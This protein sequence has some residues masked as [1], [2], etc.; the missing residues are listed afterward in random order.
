MSREEWREIP[1]WE[2]LYMAS[3]LGRVR[4][5]DRT[6]IKKV[7]RNGRMATIQ[8]KGKI[9]SQSL[10]SHGYPMLNLC[11]GG[12]RSAALVHQLVLFAFVGPKPEGM[13]SRHLDG[14]RSN[15]RIENLCWGTALENAADKKRHGTEVVIC[16]ERHGRAKLNADDVRQ[17]RRDAD[18]GRSYAS[19][20]R[21]HC[22]SAPQIRQIA[23]RSAWRHVP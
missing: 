21:E 23:V 16:G 11:A 5:I 4:S 15:N 19:I 17:I 22:I 9:I 18:A 2:G 8:R 6:I 14:V 20:G 1:G 12:K 13:E 10:D 3:N 7:S